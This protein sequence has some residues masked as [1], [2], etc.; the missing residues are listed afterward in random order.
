[1]QKAIKINSY[2]FLWKDSVRKYLKTLQQRDAQY[3]K[4][5]F[6]N[7]GRDTLLNGYTKDKF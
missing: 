5:Q 1:M 6:A 7:K 4:E 3:K 2:L